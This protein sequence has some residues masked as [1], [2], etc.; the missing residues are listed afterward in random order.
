M[1]SDTFM[2]QLIKH[3]LNIL[4]PK[5]RAMPQTVN[6]SISNIMEQTN[7]GNY[8]GWPGQSGW[9]VETEHSDPTNISWNLEAELTTCP[10]VQNGATKVVLKTVRIPTQVCTM[11]IVALLQTTA[12]DP[13]VEH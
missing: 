7:P 6:T 5:P 9:L 13:S 4:S 2:K 12:S 11:A 1:A 8:G 10:L 3:G